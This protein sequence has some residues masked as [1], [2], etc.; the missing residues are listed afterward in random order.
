MKKLISALALAVAFVLVTATPARAEEKMLGTVTKI[1][2]S[3]DGKSA[4]ATLKDSKTAAAVDI[5]VADDVTLKKFAD[6]RIGSGD[7]I[8]CKYEKKDGKNLATFFKKAGGC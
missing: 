8:K 2:V 7:E 5:T 6:H 3:K 1:D 4:V